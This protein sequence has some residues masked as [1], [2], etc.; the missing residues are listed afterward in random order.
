[1]Q[2]QE[3]HNIIRICVVNPTQAGLPEIRRGEQEI[4][5]SESSNDARDGELVQKP[6]RCEW[7]GSSWNPEDFGVANPRG[8]EWMKKQLAPMPIL[9]HQERLEAPRMKAKMIPRYL[10]HC[11]RFGLGGFADK[12]QLEGGRVFDIE[13]GHDAMITEPEKLAAILDKISS[14][15]FS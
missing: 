13:A 14:A 6:R 9:T 7:N 1:M 4:G 12:L 15:S 5:D 10:V 11:T 2:S 8:V 3:S